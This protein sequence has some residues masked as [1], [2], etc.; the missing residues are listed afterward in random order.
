MLLMRIADRQNK[1]LAFVMENYS[2][3]EVEYWRVYLSKEPDQNQMNEFLMTQLLTMFNNA[4]FKN[5]Q[6]PRDFCYPRL[7]KNDV[8]NDVDEIGMALKGK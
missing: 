3:K 6:K 8:E 2:D 4:N 1:S 7:W 5:K